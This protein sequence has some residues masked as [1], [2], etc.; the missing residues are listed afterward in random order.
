MPICTNCKEEKNSKEFNLNKKS[1]SGLQA[2]CRSCAKKRYEMWKK[3]ANAK[4][5]R[6]VRN[7][8]YRLEIRQRLMQYLQDKSCIDCFESRPAC[9]DFDHVR[10]K[11]KFNISEAVG[12]YSWGTMLNEIRKC[13]IRCA[14]CHRVH[15]AEQQNWYGDF[16]MSED[17]KKT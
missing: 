8:R 12:K 7:K 17:S 13:V 15:T 6:R 2:Y 3:T 1:K 4:E 16:N 14:N 10:G 11:K 5:S 9:L